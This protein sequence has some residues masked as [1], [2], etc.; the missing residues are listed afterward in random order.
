MGVN[1]HGGGKNGGCGEMREDGVFMTSRPRQ[2][3]RTLVLV[4]QGA[5][6]GL[7][8]M[9]KSYSRKKNSSD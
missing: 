9:V 1:E 5:H 4:C 8:L 6:K 7:I 3:Q 2:L